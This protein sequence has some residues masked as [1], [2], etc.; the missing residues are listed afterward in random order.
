MPFWS[1]VIYMGREINKE[2]MYMAKTYEPEREEHVEHDT[3]MVMLNGKLV[4]VTGDDPEV[5][6]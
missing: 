1:E 4:E 2:V 5:Q 6:E 3:V